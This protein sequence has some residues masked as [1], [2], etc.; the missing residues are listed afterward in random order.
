MLSCKEVSQLVSQSLD[1]PLPIGKRIAVRMHLMI[2]TL[3]RRY[4]RQLHFLQQATRQL[5]EHL[6]ASATLQLSDAARQRIRTKFDTGK[7]GP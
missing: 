7:E 6:D 5:P 1:R 3:C 2:C 4:Q